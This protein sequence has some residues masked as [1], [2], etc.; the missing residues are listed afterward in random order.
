MN[1]ELRKNIETEIGMLREISN[2]LHR[3]EYA[4]ENEKR[5][6]MGAVNSLQQ[7]IKIINNSIPDILKEISIA[8]KLELTG[9]QKAPSEKKLEKVEAQRMTSG[10]SVFIS[11][12][13][14]QRFLEELNINESFIKRI[15]RSR[16]KEKEIYKEFKAARGYLKLANRLFLER[17][18]KFS[19]REYF[20][21]L[22]VE[23]R[24]ANIDVLFESYIAMMFLT[25]LISLIF[26]IVLATVLLFFN[27]G[28]TFPF[29]S[30]YT[31]GFLE[32]FIK[33]IWIPLIVPVLTFI[34]L[35]YYP[36]A[37][38]KSIEGKI[39]QELPFAVIHMSAISGSGIEPSEIFRI[40]GM[41]KE[42]P[43]LRKEF[44]KVINQINLYGYDLVT[45]LNNAAKSSPS[46]M[47]AELFS[48]LS[49][50]ITS[51]SNLPIFLEKRSES[52][53][54][55]YRLERERYTRLVETLLD[56]YISI[57][58]AAPMIF[59]LL[60]IMMVVS[61]IQIGFSPSQISL[62]T[63]L[64]IAGLNVAFIMFAGAKQ[65]TY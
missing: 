22:S 56:I 51:G 44:R 50:T 37:E 33:V 52:L 64:V 40:I 8:Q 42:Y 7:S 45:A 27:V 41:S 21:M 35:F 16:K 14:K 61:G 59:L 34:A 5:L 26:G 39:N 25:V 6:I 12:K 30:V 62:L 32:R 24:K 57:V 55:N 38:K 46:E 11:R 53:L 58:I 18:K 36:S 2:Y 13:D 9:I 15:R 10:V 28:L 48:G 31:G 23:I 47:L 49:V 60:L 3:A 63:V 1:Y 65:P 54:L 17:A 43:N 20:K 29:F 4:P 19:D